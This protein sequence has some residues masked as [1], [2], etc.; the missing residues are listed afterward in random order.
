MHV[1]VTCKNEEDKTKNEG[2]RGGQEQLTP[3]CGCIW[4]KF[5]LIQVFIVVLVTRKNEEEPIKNEVDR[6]VTTLYLHF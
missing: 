3:V 4:P 5:A 2:A 6:V 1:L